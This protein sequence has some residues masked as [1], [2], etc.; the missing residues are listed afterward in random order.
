M[1]PMIAALPAFIH[2]EA[3]DTGNDLWMENVMRF[4]NVEMEND[5]PGSDAV[6]H[7]LTEIV[8]IQ[9]IRAYLARAGDEARCLAAIAD[10][11]IGRAIAAIH[12]R[13]GS[14]WTLESLAKEAA[15]SRTSFVERFGALMGMTPPQYLRRWRMIR[16]R[17]DL[18]DTSDSTSAVAHRYGYRSESAF[19]KTFKQ[20][21]GVGPGRLRRTHRKAESA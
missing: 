10:S 17:R 14:A 19:N 2:I 12:R 21:F 8:F 7:R 13:P 1:H 20:E 9:V 4:A 6:V 18:I 15:L 3:E 5:L 16:A 11:H